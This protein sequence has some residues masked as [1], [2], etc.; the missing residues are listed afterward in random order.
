MDSGDTILQKE[1]KPSSL[2]LKCKLYTAASFQRMVQKD[3]WEQFHGERTYQTLLQPGHQS[4]HR[5]SSLHRTHVIDMMRK[6][7]LATQ[8]SSPS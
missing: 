8:T 3:G 6:N 4:Q 7:N 5:Q 1:G 2:L